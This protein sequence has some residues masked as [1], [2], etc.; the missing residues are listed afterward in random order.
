[1]S[2]ADIESDMVETLGIV[3]SFFDELP[4]TVLESEWTTFKNFQLGETAIPNKYKEMIGL[5]ESAAE[6]VAR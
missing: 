1:M 3:P 5:P 2:R 6:L 4:D